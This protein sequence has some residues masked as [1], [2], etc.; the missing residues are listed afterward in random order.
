MHPPEFPMPPLALAL[1]ALALACAGA[2]S[3]AQD[4][5]RP[6]AG[7][8]VPGGANPE[9]RIREAV[10]RLTGRK[11]DAIAK[12]SFL[13]LY[14]VVLGR[15][16][17]YMDEKAQYLISGD[18]YDLR[19][20]PPRNLKEERL[21]KIRDVPIP[22]A[23]LPLSQAIKIVRGNGSRQ[24]AYF[25]DPRC[26]YCKKLEKDLLQLQDVTLHVFLFPILSPESAAQSKAV[27]CAPD[28]GKAWI[29]L[30]VNGV[31][32]KADGVCETPIEKNLAFGQKHRIEG[33]PTLVFENGRRVS[34][35]PPAERI[36]DLL[37]E[38]AKK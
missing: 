21:A 29:D 16:I 13:G 1:A 28:R 7:S 8:T 9:A 30:M 5:A 26:P 10:E 25:S 31:A 32:P 11:P 19:A 37:V 27:W 6:A 24:L 38:A 36:N 17:V 22:F 3:F 33:T 20:S 12:A 2:P 18:V 14:E 4:N 34:G 35:S 23:E 15:E